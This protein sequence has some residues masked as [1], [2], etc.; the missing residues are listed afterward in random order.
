MDK[1]A[2]TTWEYELA[3]KV[4][5]QLEIRESVLLKIV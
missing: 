3:A 5:A 4:R 1:T 2:Q